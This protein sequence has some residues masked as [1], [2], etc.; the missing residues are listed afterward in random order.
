MPGLPVATIRE[1]GG[2]TRLMVLRA[3]HRQDAPTLRAIAEEVGVT[4]QAVSEHVK[5]LQEDGHVR[6]AEAGPRLTEAGLEHLRESLAGLKEYVDQAVRELARIE[7]TAARA[8]AA[9]K[10]GDPVGL[11]MEDGDLVAYPHR[12]SPSRGRAEQDAEPG[13]DVVVASL[14]GIVQLEPGRIMVGV[15]P[16]AEAGGS[17]RA[18]LAR[19]EALGRDAQVVVALGPVA[20][21]VLERVG[22]EPVRF[23]APAVAADAAMRGV[24]SL[25]VCEA[26]ALPGLLDR[27]DAALLERGLVVEPKVMHL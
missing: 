19:V 3:L 2:L 1:K 9:I 20:R 15:V 24:D 5:R 6:P 17:R 7:S 25:V 18:D 16:D 23:G 11:F 10:T 4:V 8:G 21:H 26:Q 14:E 22:T 12:T 27:L 13:E